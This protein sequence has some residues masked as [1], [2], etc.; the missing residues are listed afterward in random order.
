MRGLAAGL[1]AGL[2]AGAFG[3]AAG[4]PRIDRAIEIE[5]Q[6]GDPATSRPAHPGEALVSRPSQRRG[7]PLATSLY[8]LAL[9]GLFGLAFAFAR[10]RIGPKRDVPLAAALAAGLFL[11][12]VLVPFVKYPANPPGV[13]DPTTIEERT[14]LYFVMLAIGLAS[15]LAAARV[16][17]SARPSLRGPAAVACFTATVGV[18][19]ALLPGVNE[20]PSDFPSDLLRDFRLVAL[21]TQAVLWGSLATLFAL[22]TERARRREASSAPVRAPT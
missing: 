21:S 8:G 16:A 2:I 9:G 17:R 14:L 11:G 3:L 13:G 1:V 15:L 4:E 7:L 18:A 5:R 20:V 6:A 22:A 10:G 12:A 19:Y